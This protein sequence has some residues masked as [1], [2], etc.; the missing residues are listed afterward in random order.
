MSKSKSESTEQDVRDDWICER[1]TI[2][3]DN[4]NILHGV[5]L[6][7]SDTQKGKRTYPET[8]RRS[9]I[10]VFE[11]Q[12]VYINHP[13]I[14]ERGRALNAPRMYEE[15]IG[16]VIE[17]SVA[18][19]GRGLIGDLELIPMH[20]QAESVKYN[21]DRKSPRIGISYRGRAKFKNLEM[22]GACESIQEVWG[23]DIVD[24]PGSGGSLR[25]SME[26]YDQGKEHGEL[27]AKVDAHENKLAEHAKKHEE[28]QANHEHHEGRLRD[29]DGHHDKHYEHHADHERRL[30]DC[31]ASMSEQLKAY[32]S[33]GG[34]EHVAAVEQWR[35]KQAAA[36]KLV[37]EA[38]KA[39]AESKE[40]FKKVPRTP[41][42]GNPLENGRK[43]PVPVTN[44]VGL[45]KSHFNKN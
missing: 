8:L 27:R 15:R 25:E 42:S 20:P 11:R 14:T 32:E 38:Q 28:H 23:L 45:Q 17:G 6:L 30:H 35:E 43:M 44:G 4:P 31:E 9:L 10:P 13:D 26:S 19:D 12:N 2:D 21:F 39:I 34:K 40:A 16:W 3:A 24:N 18:E 22:T 29:H 41:N 5:R 33:L 36:E 37:S 7:A 1:A